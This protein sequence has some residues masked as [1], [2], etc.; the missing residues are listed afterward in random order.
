[1]IVFLVTVICIQRL[2]PDSTAGIKI[3]EVYNNIFGG[4]SSL[5]G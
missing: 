3:Q 4:I 2:A 1:V 5:F